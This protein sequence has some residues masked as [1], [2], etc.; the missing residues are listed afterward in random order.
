MNTAP[1]IAALDRVN[2][3]IPDATSLIRAKVRG[4]LA[5][6]HARWQDQQYRVL[7]N[8]LGE[9]AIEQVTTSNLWNPETGRI[10]RSFTLAGKIDAL[11]TDSENRILICD[12]KTCSEDITDP[13]APYWRQLVVEGQV[14]HYMFLE[15][16]NGRKVD[17]AVWDVVRKPSISP[18]K[19]DKAELQRVTMLHEYIGQF[20]SPEDIE[21]LQKE[22]RETPSMYEARLVDDC[23][24]ERPQ[25]YF[26][27]RPIWRMDNEIVEYANELWGHGQDL[28]NARNE[29]RHPRNSGACMN[30]GR[31]CRYLGIC[32]G[33]DDPDSLKWARKE[34]V[35]PELEGLP[36]DGRDV[37]TNTRIR[38]FQTCRKKH[39]FD[40]EIGLEKSA[41]EAETLY[42]GSIWHKAMETWWSFYGVE[43]NHQKEESN[44]NTCTG[45][46]ATDVVTT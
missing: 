32:S 22:G 43:I 40:Y 39:E 5:G 18:R 21:A 15:W 28:L 17:G 10:S 42:F 30:Y 3:E 27:R 31:P 35:H 36:G 25:W 16:L 20:V 37:L 14:S 4:L 45:S 2:R 7:R 12:H 6:Y 1:L 23:I 8:V 33:A 13:N 38:T 44:V 46:A 34:N 11:I 41:E 26:Q 9:M 19:L 24:R 29:N